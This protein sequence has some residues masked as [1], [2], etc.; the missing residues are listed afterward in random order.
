ML[1]YKLIMS[2]NAKVKGIELSKIKQKKIFLKFIFNNWYHANV[3]E[4][5]QNGEK[6]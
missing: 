3:M 2:L 4:K 6:K 5:I 1:M